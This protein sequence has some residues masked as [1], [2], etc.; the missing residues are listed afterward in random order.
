[1]IS[2]TLQMCLSDDIKSV[3]SQQQNAGNNEELIVACVIIL[4]WN[5]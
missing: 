1:M 5:F 2:D 3:Y 4:I